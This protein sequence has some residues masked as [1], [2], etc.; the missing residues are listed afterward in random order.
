MG[1]AVD[2][3]GNIYI[4]DRDNERIRKVNTSGIISTIA[5]NGTIGYS[6]DGGAATNASLN[7]PTGLLV[8]AAGNIYIA[9]YFNSRI[10]KVNT[11]GVIS[12]VAGN[13]LGSYSGDGGLQ[14]VLVCFIQQGLHWM[15]RGICI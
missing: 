15:L 2:Y 4:A 13:G 5:G 9:D 14:L 3:A 7:N 6:G 10:R 12:T 8:D 11:N 1:V